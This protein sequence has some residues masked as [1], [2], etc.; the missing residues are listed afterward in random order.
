MRCG[1]KNRFAIRLLLVL[2]KTNDY[3]E[4][5]TKQQQVLVNEMF[6][7]QHTARV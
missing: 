7:N 4:T 6:E 5:E 3:K 1:K 2:V